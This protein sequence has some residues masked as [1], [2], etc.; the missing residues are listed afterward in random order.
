MIQRHPFFQFIKLC[1][2]Q[3]PGQLIIQMTDRCNAHCPQCSMRVTENF[4]RNSLAPEQCKQI[5]DKAVERGVQALSITGGEPLLHFNQVC[6]VI[7]Y[8]STAGI[9]Y[10]R[11]GTNGY[12]FRNPE[13]ADFM[14]RAKD[15]VEKIAGSSVRNFWISIDS[16]E[17]TTHENM[18]GFGNVIKGIEKVIPLFH[19]N[20]LYPT[21]NLGINR[22]L[23]GSQPSFLTN[24]KPV[25]PEQKDQFVDSVQKGL[26]NFFRLAQELGFTIVNFC[27][28]MSAEGNDE[29]E[30]V[31]PASSAEHIVCFS[32]LEKSWLFEAMLEVVPQFRSSLRIFSP[33]STIDTMKRFYNKETITPFPCKGGLDYFFI[34]AGDGKTYPCGYRGMNCY[35]DYRVVDP[36]DIPETEK[37]DCI[38]CDWECFR[39]PTEFFGPLSHGLG[40]PLSIFTTYKRDKEFYKLWFADL[41]Y[42]RACDFFNGRKDLNSKKLASY[43]PRQ[44]R[45]KKGIHIAQ[46]VAA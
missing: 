37:F 17:P 4:T 16:A 1:K 41:K 29:L 39:D 34:N 12:L 36:T 18:R 8:A 14:D 5:I 25:V 7:Q 2:G 20:G 45:I 43:S 24:R 32:N 44:Q 42:Y 22:N 40:N 3:T 38:R 26:S 27:Y 46:D 30:A 13:S 9:K 15:I 28:P 35:G 31:Y 6:D 19:A 23:G 21:A 11:T 10:T 33:L